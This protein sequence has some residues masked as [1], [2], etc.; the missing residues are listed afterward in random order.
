MPSTENSNRKGITKL[1]RCAAIIEIENAIE[2]VARRRSITLGAH[3][4]PIRKTRIAAA[5]SASI[6]MEMIKKE[7]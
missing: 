3:S 6:T 4:A 7:R 5:E 1:K 2:E